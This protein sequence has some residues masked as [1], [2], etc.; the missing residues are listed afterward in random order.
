MAS[1]F[2]SQG[3]NF[4]TF[5]ER[6]VDP[7]TGQY[8]CAISI[9]KCPSET[10]NCPPLNLSICYSPLNTQDIGLG[11]GWRF[12]VTQYQHRGSDNCCLSLSTGDQYR[13]TDL[14]DSLIVKDNK[15][16]NFMFKKKNIQRPDSGKDEN[17]Y[18]VVYKS[19]QVEVLSNEANSFNTSVPVRIYATNGKQLNL[20]WNAFGEQP[21]LT[22][23][24]E[25][26]Q[27]LLEISYTAAGVDIVRN[28]GTSESS[29]FSILQTNGLLTEIR[30]P[31][32]EGETKQSAWQFSY[33]ASNNEVSGFSTITSPAGLVEQLQYDQS[34]HRLPDGAPSQTIPYVALHT[35][36]PGQ[37]Q[38]AI[39]TSYQ[40]SDYNFLGYGGCVEWKDG[41][42]NLYL[43]PDDYQYT[44]TVKVIGGSTTTNVYN[45]F[46][47][48]VESQKQKDSKRVTQT[49]D[50]YALRYV[51]FD[52]QP[53]Q[54][55]MPRTVT[56]TFDDTSSNKSRSQVTQHEF[57]EWG[58]PT[59]EV[60]PS[61]IITTRVYYAANGE[62][63][64]TTGDVRCPADPHGFQRY[65]KKVTMTPAASSFTTPTRSWEYTYRELPAAAGGYTTH[66]V[67]VEEMKCLE[68]NQCHSSTKYKFINEPSSRDHSRLKQD[69]TRLA[70]QYP[71]VRTV[72]YQYPS[73]D[74]LIETTSTKTFDGFAFQEQS[75]QSLLT[76]VMTACQDPRGI[77]ST[78]RYNRIGRLV[79]EMVA[80]GTDHQ[81]ARQYEHTIV[82]RG[83]GRADGICLTQT[84]AKG[85]KQRYTVDGL[86]RICRIENQDDDGE[87]VKKD[88]LVT[89][90]GT[91]R[92]TQEHLYNSLNQCIEVDA[93]D[94]LK[95]GSSGDGRSEQRS[96]TYFEYD[97]W[98]QEYRVKSGSGVV[99]YTDEDPISMTRT[100]GIEGE[101]KAVTEMNHSGA[102][103]QKKMFYKDGNLYSKAKWAYDGL[104]RVRQQRNPLDYTSEF[105]YDWFDRIT[106]T[107]PPGK[108]S[109][110]HT[111]YADH[112]AAAFPTSMNI[113]GYDAIA[114]QSF[115]GLGRIQKVT[116]GGRTTGQSYQGCDPSPAEVTTPKGA[117]QELGY[118][119]TLDGA[120]TSLS[121]PDYKCSYNY[122]PQTAET[123]Q[124]K[125]DY[126][127]RDLKYSPAGLVTA[128][129]FRRKAQEVTSSLENSGF[130]YS[131]SGRIQAYTDVH[132]QAHVIQYDSFGRP[133]QLTQG[134][135]N[136]TFAYDK[137]DRL[138][139]TCVKDNDDS[140]L[141]L[142]TRLSFDDFGREIERAVSKA[143]NKLLYRV[144]QTYNTVGL[145]EGR[146]QTDSEGKLLRAES[147]QYDDLNRLVDYQC[148]GSEKWLPTEEG[149][150]VLKHQQFTFDEYNCIAKVS[151]EFQDG[152]MNT[153]TYTYSSQDPTQLIRVTNTHNDYPARLDIGYD[154]NGCLINDGQGHAM[155][156]DSMNRLRIV[157]DSA[158]QTILSQYQY[159]ADGR[160]VCQM[161]PGKPDVH[162][163]YQDG[164]LIAT[165]AGDSQ[166][167]Y[168]S[169]GAAYW[170][171]TTS[172]KGDRKQTHRIWSSDGHGS[173]L[174]HL[175]SNEPTLVNHQ[176]YTPY[177][178]VSG[179]GSNF[180]SIGYNGEW[181]DPVTGWYHLGNGYRVYNP[182]LMRFLS[183]DILSPFA[184]GEINGYAYCLGDPNNRIDPSGHFSIF[185]FEISFRDLVV[186]GVGLGVGIL[187]GV[188]TGGAGL[189]IAIGASVA[190]GVVSDVVTGATYDLATGKMPTWESI[191]TDAL[192]G[193]IGG[194]VGEAVARGAGMALK[195]GARRLGRGI[196]QLLEGGAKLRMAGP[197][198]P[199]LLP[200]EKLEKALG[201]YRR[202][203]RTANDIDNRAMLQK[204][205][206]EIRSR[207]PWQWVTGKETTIG[208]SKHDPATHLYWRKYSD[209]QNLVRG[210]RLSPAEAAKKMG[211]VHYEGLGQK[212]TYSNGLKLQEYTVRLSQQHRVAFTINEETRTV[213]VFQIGGHY[214]KARR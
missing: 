180:T 141:C 31:L 97:N 61:G 34:G 102:P 126:M 13:I 151:S 125:N 173:V 175:D 75:T 214:P 134:T 186:A 3:F 155:E 163:S 79:K 153:A 27:D 99:T 53:A 205:V 103:I 88:G 37:G 96:K 118:Q 166:V 65:V 48:V 182:V 7:R 51:P 74:R 167:S 41:E 100:E 64:A 16:Q 207:R 1:N 196:D 121:A 171:Q 60:A 109:V 63:D 113:E 202:T 210:Q 35:V 67:V 9:F 70:E 150:H 130:V 143:D 84:D 105:R 208:I 52:E 110:V 62:K 142:T 76:G 80:P 23:I 28:P 26:G 137:A 178:H 169:D 114:K 42:D 144:T 149:A 66:S 189:A 54:Y 20:V 204:M 57:D 33:E 127:T 107:I 157:K 46:H 161:I 49:I 19:G 86:E 95:D 98:G 38:P 83:D 44:S 77:Q 89:Y 183:P 181:R 91:F 136:V 55:Q 192:F 56:T 159:D 72:A 115:D 147:F 158:N 184:S 198:D 212:K 122:D 129:S 128:E 39:E 87:W 93:I 101:G 174:A 133:Q 25:G 187:V 116:V 152:S 148:R 165:T 71:T 69:T 21:R 190:S 82:T 12:N 145:V 185:G 162:F 193:A 200:L 209:F 22:K 2:Y 203:V 68:D 201:S 112:S 176:Q 194:V 30:L 177:G 172:V 92:V 188:L 160:L 73:F 50:Y 197:H 120:L 119:R 156:Y 140:N 154:A 195:S 4:N 111:Q 164:N 6:G 199:Q 94:W 11:R 139:E 14:S 24:Q 85:V 15:L 131:I 29:T 8:T 179:S 138:W 108:H 45:K 18:E 135:V 106:Q 213:H 43:V 90:S 78:F 10:R 32:E 168:L 5:L 211:D 36:Y 123:T 40:F 104:G 117:I 47:L 17:T 146:N 59:K 132:G 81:A 124:R 170:G 206:H 58:N 191:G